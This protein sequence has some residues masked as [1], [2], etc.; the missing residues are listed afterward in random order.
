MIYRGGGGLGCFLFFYGCKRGCSVALAG[1]T[2][3]FAGTWSV[4]QGGWYFYGGWICF[5][6][7]EQKVVKYAAVYLSTLE[8]TNLLF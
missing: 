8:G 3:I 6:L 1:F 7:E 5:F 2:G 4:G